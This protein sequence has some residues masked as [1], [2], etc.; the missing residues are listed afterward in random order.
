MSIAGYVSVCVQLCCIGFH[1]LS[2]H[3]SVYMVIFRCVG[4]FIFI[5]LKNSASLLLFSLLASKQTHTQET[6]K[7]T[8]ENNTGTK[9]RWKRAECDHVGKK[10]QKEKAAK[11][12]PSGI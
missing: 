1:C 9:H 3:V 4:Y 2:L 10:R 7:F 12:N 5:C 8:K 6:T 11:Q